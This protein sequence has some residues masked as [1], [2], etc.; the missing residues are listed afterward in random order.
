M[1]LAGRDRLQSGTSCEPL[2]A[3]AT[4]NTQFAAGQDYSLD[5][6]ARVKQHLETCSSCLREYGLWSGVSRLVKKHCGCDPA[7]ADLRAKVM[8]RINMIAEASQP[9]P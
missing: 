3:D 2:P 8:A 1:F 4:G 5:K 9:S 7:P 6:R